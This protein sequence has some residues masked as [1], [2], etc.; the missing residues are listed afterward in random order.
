VRVF[1]G[2]HLHE[3]RGFFAYDPIFAGGVR[4]AA[5]D[6]DQD[7]HAEIITGPG[8][9][10]GPYARVWDGATGAEVTGFFTYDAAFTGGIFVA[11]PTAQSRMAVDSPVLATTVA[12]TFTVSGWAAAGN[13]STDSGVDAVHV[14]AYPVLGGAPIFV[15]AAT[16]GQPRP[17]V[18]ALFGGTF[19]DSGYTLM[20]GPLAAGTYD[21]VVIAHN[22]RT[23]LFDNFR[24][25]RFTVGP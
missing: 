15:G 3:I 17:D 18:A 23:G 10:G 20:A 22:A 8:T 4:V 1:S 9:G 13:A 21:L 12:A 11:A 2:A 14:W 7:G 5:G 24:I 19:A 6:L 25:I 16:V